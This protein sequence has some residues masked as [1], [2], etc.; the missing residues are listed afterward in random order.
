MTV[1][2]TPAT[3]LAGVSV[4]DAGAVM[5]VSPVRA[6]ATVTLAVGAALSFTVTDGLLPSATAH[7]RR[8]DDDRSALRCSGWCSGSRAGLLLGPPL[9]VGVTPPVVQVVLFSV[10]DVGLP[11]VPVQRP[12]KPT[13]VDAP[14][15]RLPL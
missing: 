11:L 4:T 1:T 7:R 8:R 10:N 15:P 9:G 5:L 12:L 2:L 13:L 14:V 3:A 6:R